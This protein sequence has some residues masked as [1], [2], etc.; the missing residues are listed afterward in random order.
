V[1]MPVA[2]GGLSGGMRSAPYSHL[3]TN[4]PEGGVAVTVSQETIDAWGRRLDA[5]SARIARAF[6]GERPE[7]QP[8]HTVYGGAHLFAADTA[9]KLGAL[10][11]R[12]LEEHAPDPRTHADALGM[13]SHDVADQ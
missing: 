12:T 10:A 1:A 5:V 7:R 3:G 13:A 2:L 9:P 11:K 8:V 6:P 4:D